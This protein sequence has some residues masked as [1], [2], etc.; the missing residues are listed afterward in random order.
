MGA[1]QN[2]HQQTRLEAILG[3]RSGLSQEAQA[4]FDSLFVQG[5]TRDDV[6]RATGFTPD[7]IDRRVDRLLHQLRHAAVAPGVPRMSSLQGVA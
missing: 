4:L 2:M 7:E 6:S 5:Q 1:M 3:A